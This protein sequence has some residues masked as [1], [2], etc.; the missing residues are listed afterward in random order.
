MSLTDGRIVIL[1]A[2][3]AGT[4][5]AA[6]LRRSAFRGE[7]LVLH[8]EPTPPYHRPA[9]AKGLL[10]GHD[11]PK[12]VPLDLSDAPDVSWQLGSTAVAL[13]PYDQV[14]LTDRDVQLEYDGLVVATGSG[15]FVPPGW[16]VGE[17]GVHVVY[18]LDDAIRLRGELRGARR[19]VV[20]GAGMT[21]CETASAVWS[22]GRECVLVDPAEEVLARPLGRLAG[23][24]VTDELGRCGVHL[25]LGRRVT[26]L[27]RQRR[28]WVVELDDG[29]E[30]TGDVVVAALGERPQTGL[31]GDL[32][33]VD[34]T[35]GLLCDPA[36]RVLGLP[37]TVAAGS[38]ARWPNLRFAAEP[39]RVS[40][41]LAAWETGRGAAQT[42]LAGPRATPVTVVP[43]FWSEQFGLR[44]QSCGV[45]PDDAEVT[46]TPTRPGRR[47]PA[48]GGMVFGYHAGDELVGLAAIN[49]PRQFTTLAR[50]LLAA[51]G[52]RALTAPR[53]VTGSQPVT[54][55]HPVTASP[56]RGT[57]ARG[58]LASVPPP[59]PARGRPALAAV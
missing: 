12:D 50:Y 20:V 31:F 18:G 29:T 3:R 1:G 49:A 38:V 42:L 6:E 46:V 21:G 48:R 47:S 2:G 8:D 35:D 41:W 11:R 9:C 10:T 55:R 32:R 40:Q 58:T 4:A 26:G 7:V 17:P 37:N 44:I 57:A 33:E 36:L 15:A 30:V 43:R 51:P 25:R 14:V 45:L 5:A 28:G 27:T 34:A 13:D 19:V 52:P 16:P 39:V 56:S 24:L 59:T 23:A 54:A 53:L 22:T